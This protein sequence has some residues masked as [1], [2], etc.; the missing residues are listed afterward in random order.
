MPTYRVTDP[1]T[2][3]TVKLTGDSPPTEAELEEIFASLSPQSVDYQ[4]SESVRNFPSSLAGVG[5][6]ML[7]AVLSPVDTA[8]ALAGTVQGGANKLG[9]MAAEA[10][11]GREAPS[12]MPGMETESFDAVVDFYKDRYGSMDAFKT[13][14]ME[15]PAAVMMDAAAVLTPLKGAPGVVGKS[16]AIADPFQNLGRAG[17]V[18]AKGVSAMTP[19]Q[20][21]VNWY[22]R[23]AKFTNARGTQYQNKLAET[24]LRERIVPD[25]DGVALVYDRIGVLNEQL[26]EMIN[27]ATQSG[28][29]IP[30]DAVYTRLNELRRDIGNLQFEGASDLKIIDDMARDFSELAKS[31][32]RSYFTPNELLA[33]KRR[34][35]DKANY[36]L[37]QLN[38]PTPQAV[39]ETRKAVARGADDALDRIAPGS[40]QVND[41]LSD[42]IELV[43]NIDKQAGRIE[44]HNI[45]GLTT[46]LNMVGGVLAGQA[47]GNAIAGMTG[48]TVLNILKNPRVM[49]RTAVA[50]RRLKD[51]DINWIKANNGAMEVRL[52]LYLAE[53][54]DE[55]LS[56]LE[57][58]Q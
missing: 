16:A 7:S 17:K 56:D 11:S 34:T 36:N 43:N 35:Q 18:V 45:I 57:A 32:N 49:T 37:N 15:D 33:F 44:N 13:T 9:L 39:D 2:G 31:Q 22:K 48:A 50:L 28:K 26:T 19:D 1:E 54:A 52:A 5:K 23:A 6:D 53:N 3:K 8:T 38:N 30:I 24:A 58:S 21:L 46:P 27:Q 41:R 51:G 29:K 42:L 40:A 20:A 4:F 14:L 12:N 55:I 47:A 25:S 10:V